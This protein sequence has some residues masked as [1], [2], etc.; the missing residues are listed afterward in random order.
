[1]NKKAIIFD[2]DGTL[3]PHLKNDEMPLFIE[4]YNNNEN[5][6]SENAYILSCLKEKGYDLF[7]A[8]GS[9]EKFGKEVISLWTIE[10]YFIELF[11]Y[12]G[13]VKAEELK[14][15]LSLLK[16]KYETV[17]MVGDSDKNDINPAREVGIPSF[18]INYTEGITL[19]K[20]YK[21]ITII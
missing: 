1:M 10:K 5:I 8:S 17:L 11:F 20:W 2:M 6:F 18:K 12:E 19:E 4:L 13:K 15:T 7:L 14:S 16:A 21:T 9:K 3:Y